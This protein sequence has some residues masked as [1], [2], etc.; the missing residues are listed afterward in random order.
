M[1]LI[2]PVPLTPGMV[3]A[4][5]AGPADAEYN[6]ATSYTL[7]ARVY[8]PADGNT[9]ECVQS[10]ALGKNPPSN[11]LFWMKAEPS[12]RWAM[13][14][15]EIST[16]TRVAGNITTSLKP[17]GRYN[18]VTLHG[19]EGVSVTVTV[20]DAQ[21]AEIYNQTRSLIS[22]VV[23]WYDYFLSDRFFTKDL[24]FRDIPPASDSTLSIAITGPSA[25]CAAVTVG[26]EYDI[27]CLQYGATTSII[28][29]SKKTTSDTGVQSLK[30]GRYSKRVSGQLFQDRA[31]YAF[32]SR[33]LESVR[34]TACVWVG[35]EDQGDL[36]PL[37]VLGFY[38]DFSIEVSY[39]THHV[40]S[41][42][43]EGMTLL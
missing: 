25:A 42:E 22:D 41:I 2:K 39:P 10:P 38:R 8:V 37:I 6:P 40:C 16:T 13:F 24:V 33:L 26:T 4:S 14:D 9:Y 19:L 43:I 11:P 15:A 30:Q 27:G 21:G 29:Y 34:A 18:T 28:D 36:D 1:L 23:T 20:I 12:N 7:G 32:I 17:G 3:T 5:N 35:A 31:R